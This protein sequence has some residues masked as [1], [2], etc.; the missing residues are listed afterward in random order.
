ARAPLRSP[1]P[2]PA[3]H[4]V[5][6]WTT[7][8][9]PRRAQHHAAAPTRSSRRERTPPHETTSHGEG[10]PLTALIR[11]PAAVSLQLTAL[12]PSRSCSSDKS[13][14]SAPFWHNRDWIA[15]PVGATGFETVTPRL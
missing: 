10:P 6:I 9:A 7:A 15:Y 4:R 14:D 8:R 3:T 2:R 11:E 12:R 5:P 13:Q 1:S